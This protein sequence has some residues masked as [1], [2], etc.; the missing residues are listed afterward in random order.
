MAGW[1]TLENLV[2]E[3]LVQRKQEGCDI[4]GFAERFSKADGDD[5]RLMQVYHDLMELSPQSD[6]P[7]VE[8]NDLPSIR[9]QRPDGPRIISASLS[10]AQWQDKFLGAWL[11]RCAGCA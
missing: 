5:Q 10:E 1:D 2:R 9:A 6:F 11:G 3:E 7:Y 4:S 8:P